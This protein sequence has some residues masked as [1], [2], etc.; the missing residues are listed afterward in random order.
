MEAQTVFAILVGA[1]LACFSL[2]MVGYSF[3]RGN[4]TREIP[5]VAS[6]PPESPF[7]P[8]K[9]GADEVGVDAIL[10][11]INTL[12]LEYQ[13]GNVTDDQ[14]RE[15]MASY[16]MQVA[17]A[18]KSQLE[19]GDASPELLLEQEILEARAADGWR[20]CPRCDAPLP[21]TPPLSSGKG[22]SGDGDAPLAFCPHCN[23]SLANDDSSSSPE[24]PFP[25]E[26][27]GEA[28][29]VPSRATEQ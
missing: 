22:L 24:S 3:F 8:E 23:A 6:A 27:G 19:R 5:P 12:D 17:V 14:Y 7:P 13:L 4:E 2:L 29:I 18:V 25:P 9:G 20:S 21:V 11:S 26:K 28:A 10:D 1:A 15:Q 16:R